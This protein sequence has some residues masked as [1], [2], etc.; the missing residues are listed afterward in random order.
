[1]AF[2]ISGGG[3]DARGRLGGQ[4]VVDAL[5]RG[6]SC[7]T[8]SKQNWGSPLDEGSSPIK[9]GVWT[10]LVALGGVV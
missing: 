6:C 4:G 2:A 1:M 5:I 3:L 7:D 8:G 9:K 10:L